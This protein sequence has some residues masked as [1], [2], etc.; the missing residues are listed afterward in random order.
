[1]TLFYELAADLRN[2]YIFRLVQDFYVSERYNCCVDLQVL[3]KIALSFFHTITILSRHH[4]SFAPLQFYM[5][6]KS[7]TRLNL[8][9][10]YIGL[11]SFLIFFCQ[12]GK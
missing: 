3:H 9:C 10:L 7:V 5:N 12:K 11:Y 4:H 1:M 6:K 2:S 8:L